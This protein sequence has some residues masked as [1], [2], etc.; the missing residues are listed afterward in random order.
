MT[1]VTETVITE[2]VLVYSPTAELDRLMEEL[3]Q[4]RRESAAATL[5][6][7]EGVD[8][9][10]SNRLSE[11]SSSQYS[12]RLGPTEEF[13]DRLEQIDTSSMPF[14]DRVNA[15]ILK[16]QLRSQAESLRFRTWLMPLHIGSG[17]HIGF[18]RWQKNRSFDTVQEYDQF[19]ARL[20]S[21]REHTG[22][23]IELMRE[24]VS[25]GMTPVREQLVGFELTVEP[26][27]TQDVTEN[28]FYAPFLN[29]PSHFSDAAR[30]RILRDGREA[31]SGSL[32]P[33]MEDL[34]EFVEQE[35]RPGARAAEG[36]GALPGGNRYYEWQVRINTT[37]DVTPEELHEFGLELADRYQAEMEEVMGRTDFE[38]DFAAFLNHLRTHPDFYVES[39]ED[40]VRGL[41]LVSK[42]MEEQLYTLFGTLPKTPYGIVPIP[43]FIAPRT[44]WAYYRV[45]SP[46]NRAGYHA[47]NLYDLSMR[48]TFV[49]E[50]L[51]FHE[52]VPGHHLQIML[53]RENDE[54]PSFRRGT[55]VGVFVE[56]WAQYSEWLGHEAGFYTDPYR[57]I[58][59]LTFDM[60]R[61]GRIVINTGIHAHGWSRDQAIDWLY[62]RIPFQRQLLVNEV[63]RH[64]NGHAYPVTYKWGGEKMHELRSLAEEALGEHFDQRDFHD[65]ILKNGSMPLDML[66]LQMEEWLNEQLGK[67]EEEAEE[68]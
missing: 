2:P 53:Q 4:F 33:G 34:L 44:V 22:Q 21:F 9:R 13:L 67:L 32:I 37:S 68:E 7:P 20:Q 24:G 19:I 39:E 35:Y 55:E 63:D 28:Y 25:A 26:F 41:S 57:H 54:I 50:P 64:Y 8:E 27:I 52:G 3:Q 49:M 6:V 48:P 58:G 51:A 47:V 60:L 17:F 16:W 18:A 31:I 42:R 30:E 62:E 15:E 66:D 10:Y 59:R 38:G 45:G 1:R 14:Q 12:A 5:P 43:D 65:A 23:Q 36:I 11:V 56:G 29:L 46:G 40:Y 61:A